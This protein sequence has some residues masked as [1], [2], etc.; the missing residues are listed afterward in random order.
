M[1]RS[2]KAASGFMDFL[3]V[4]EAVTV[5]TIKADSAITLIT[6]KIIQWKNRDSIHH[7]ELFM[8]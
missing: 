4:T 5:A 8:S 2:T 6:W 7:L 3:S 1:G